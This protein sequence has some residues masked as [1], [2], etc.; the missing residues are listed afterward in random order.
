MGAGDDENL[1][2]LKAKTHAGKVNRIVENGR[3]RDA[4]VHE[5]QHNDAANESSRTEQPCG[6]FY[7]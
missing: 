7:F 3:T 5:K 6:G 2:V 4:V 1:S